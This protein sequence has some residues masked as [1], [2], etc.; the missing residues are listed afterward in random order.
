MKQIIIILL[1]II[2]F[3]A[4]RKDNLLDDKSAKLEFS[5]DTVFFDTVFTS[6]GSI[7]ERIK[8]Y[9]RNDKPVEIDRV[10]LKNGTASNFKLNVDGIQGRNVENVRIEANDSIF[11]FIEVTVDPNGGTTPLVIEDQLMTSLNGNEQ[12]IDLVAWGQDAYFWPSFAFQFPGDSIALFTDKP[13]VFYGYSLVDSLTTLII[14][15]GAQIHFHSGSGLIV[16]NEASLK[17]RGSK[18]RPVLIQGDRLEDFFKD[19]PGQWDQIVLTQ[20]SKNNEVNHAIIKNGSIGLS[21]GFTLDPTI[22]D[23]PSMK[24]RNSQIL[25]MSYIGLIGID[26]SIDAKNTVIANCGDHTVAL[27]LGGDYNFEHCTFANYWDNNPRSKAILLLSNFSKSSDGTIFKR[28]LN[29]R[30]ANSILHGAL[31]SEF[32]REREKGVDFNYVFDQMIMKLDTE[33]VENINHF[34]GIIENPENQL[35]ENP[36]ESDYSLREGSGAIDAGKQIGITLD[37]LG[38]LR[39]NNPDL[40]AYEYIP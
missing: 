26:G 36:A 6:V 40:G 20:T 16:G 4:C 12:S 11:V 2:A 31:D 39:D 17:I 9:N 25:N 21:V 32:Q 35:F 3:S 33:S 15:E 7:T 37:L 18:D 30:F 19:A 38:N 5:S 27:V 22:E 24:I 1:G 8:L 23:H 34:E 14:P 28:D 10:W 29:A 13:H